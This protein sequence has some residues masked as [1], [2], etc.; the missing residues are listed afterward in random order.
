MA[1]LLYIESSPRKDRSA[2]IDI[3]KAFLDEYEKSH[4]VAIATI[5]Y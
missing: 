2:S 4:S 1:K 3:S 5:Q